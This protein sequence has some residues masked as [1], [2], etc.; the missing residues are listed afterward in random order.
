MKKRL[1]QST[2]LNEIEK[3]AY[4]LVANNKA[5][6]MSVTGTGPDTFVYVLK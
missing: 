2:I 5:S 1:N 4:F 6:K 3:Q